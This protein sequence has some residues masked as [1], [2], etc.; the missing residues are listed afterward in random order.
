MRESEEGQRNKKHFRMFSKL[1]FNDALQY[2]EDRKHFKNFQH[3][4][5]KSEKKKEIHQ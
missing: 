1:T 2:D 3:K 4:T 5:H